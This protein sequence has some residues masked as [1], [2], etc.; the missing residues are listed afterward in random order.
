MDDQKQE[1]RQKTLGLS[2]SGGG[3]QAWAEVAA[4]ADLER[5]GVE[6][7]AVTGTSMGLF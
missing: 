5:Q 6:I 7:D 4:Y 3:V 2:F 1:Y